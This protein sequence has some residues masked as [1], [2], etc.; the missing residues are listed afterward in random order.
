MTV[1]ETIDS[2][3]TRKRRDAYGR[4]TGYHKRYTQTRPGGGIHF[5][6]KQDVS[7]FNRDLKQMFTLFRFFRAKEPKTLKYII[8][9]WRL[10]HIFILARKDNPMNMRIIRTKP[11]D[12][13]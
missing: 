10:G 1:D 12:T 5:E 4:T 7:R 6:D 9:Q 2:W 8:E 3:V 11:T 13:N